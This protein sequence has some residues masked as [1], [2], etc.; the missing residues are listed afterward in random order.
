[1]EIEEVKIDIGDCVEITKGEG[2]GERGFVVGKVNIGMGDIAFIVDLEL[3]GTETK[4]VEE[5]KR[6]KKFI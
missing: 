6:I 5:I 2:L 4:Q 1:M 3:G